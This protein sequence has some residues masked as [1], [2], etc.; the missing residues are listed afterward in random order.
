MK[1]FAVF[2]GAANVGGKNVFRPAKLA[3]ELA[4]LDVVN[5]GAAGT[6][7]VRGKATAA[8]IR[9]EILAKMAFP[10]DMVVLPGK[11]V[12]ALVESEPFAA[13]KG[14]K[15]VRVWGA[16]LVGKPAAR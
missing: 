11:D 9:R 14:S 6:F 7:V 2:L 16:A 3:A 15:D 8:A 4:H 10:I 12:V 5:V 13:V 1:A